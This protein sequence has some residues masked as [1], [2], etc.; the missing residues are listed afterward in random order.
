MVTET[1]WFSLLLDLVNAAFPESFENANYQFMSRLRNR[2]AR[3]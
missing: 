2:L 1:A 3:I